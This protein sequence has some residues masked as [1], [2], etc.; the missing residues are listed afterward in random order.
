MKTTAQTQRHK[1]TETQSVYE[2]LGGSAPLRLCVRQEK[3]KSL[4]LRVTPDGLVA[5]IPHTLDHDGPEVCR[6][7][8]RGL[9][10]LAKP[11]PPPK[12]LTPQAL[13][14]LVAA[15]AERVGV[16]VERVRIRAMRTKWASCSSRGTITLSRALLQLPRDLVEYVVCHEL[17][18]LK[19]PG[20]GKGWQALM[21]IYIPGWREREKRLAGWVLME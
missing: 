18:H 19:I 5:L 11:L 6:F 16:E 8:E 17:A 3:R 14:D 12:P 13:R 20:H 9:G 10:K 1:D 7:I 21:T 4:A 15:W 2:N